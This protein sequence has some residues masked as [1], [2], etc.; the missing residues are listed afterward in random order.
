M[1]FTFLPPGKK[2]TFGNKCKFHHPERGKQSSHSLADELRENAA[3]KKQSSTRSSPVPG[4][5]LLLVEDM[6][7][8]LSLGP[9][10]GGG[11][12]KT[13]KDQKK[14]QVR[15]SQ[16]SS[17]RTERSS[18]QSPDHGSASLHAES[19]EQ[20]DSGLGSI[21]SWS[22]HQYGGSYGSLQHLHGLRHKFCP[23]LGVVCSCCSHSSPPAYHHQ[24]GE[25]DLSYRLPH[26]SAYGP[27]PINRHAFS[28]PPEFQ[29][30][31]HHPQQQ[32]QQQHRYWSAPFGTRPH[33]HP[34]PSERTQHSMP[35]GAQGTRSSKGGEREAVR[36]KLLAIFSAQLVDTAMEMFPRELDP[37][38]LVAE[39][40]TLQSQ[41]G[42]PMR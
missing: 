26:F 21:D 3:V 30:S 1:L 10:G 15:P 23:P 6:A 33:P 40:V 27:Y 16:C 19:Q 18:R 41:Q 38:V 13:K 24:Q 2:C 35:R 22:D 37:Q 11:P 8:K 28:Q 5:S 12:T 7:K 29:H 25:S 39:I 9:D 4:Q 17:K 34:P 42:R 14:D 32:Q 20:L 31:Q 36:K